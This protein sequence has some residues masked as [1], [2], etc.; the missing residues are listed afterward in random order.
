[1]NP[2]FSGVGSYVILS[3]EH[4]RF[5]ASCVATH[6]S[7]V[8]LVRD[9]GFSYT[10]I[11]GS[12]GRVKESSVAVYGLDLETARY[13]A[14]MLGQESIV[15]AQNGNVKLVY[16]NG[17]NAGK[18]HMGTGIEVLSDVPEDDFSVLDGVIFRL[19]FDFDTFVEV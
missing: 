18:G 17:P 10:E 2:V 12:W 6:E 5:P 11:N 9:S 14:M 3:G 7:L 8:S 13:W 19:G 15:Y 4:P 1:M 16:T